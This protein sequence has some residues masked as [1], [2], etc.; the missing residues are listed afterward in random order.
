MFY[1]N[2]RPSVQ[3]YDLY[4]YSYY[5]VTL[6]KLFLDSIC[7]GEVEKKENITFVFVL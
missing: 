3:Y 2:E 5:P 7:M 6:L 4:S 1:N